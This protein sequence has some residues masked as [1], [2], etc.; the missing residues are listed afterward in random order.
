MTQI[1]IVVPCYNEEAVLPETARRLTAML[2]RLVIAGKIAEDS[3]VLFVDDGSQDQTWPLIAHLCS[4]DSRIHGIKLSRNVGHQRA[5]LAGLLT[6]SGDALISIDADLQDDLDVIEQMVDAYRA[7]DEVVYGVR[8]QRTTDTRFKRMTAHAFYKMMRLLGADM[9]EDHA[10][11]RLMGRRAI[12][13]LREFREVNLFLRGLV[14]M[15]GFPSSRV[16]Y[17]RAERLAGESKYPLHK[18]LGLALDGI[19]SLSSFPLRLITYV[20]LVVFFHH[21]WIKHLDVRRRRLQHLHRPRLGL[22]SATNL[23]HRGRTDSMHRYTWRV[24][25]KNLSRG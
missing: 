18:M 12:E 5:L 3:L 13:G 21:C 19:T 1:A 9:I 23:L 22:D 6:A 7:G 20:G 2:T 11:F 8:W 17:S 16:H 14:P 4:V 10:D 25:G 15:I 24:C